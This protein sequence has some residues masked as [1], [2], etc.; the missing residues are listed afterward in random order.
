MVLQQRMRDRDE[1]K[2]RRIFALPRAK[3]RIYIELE[4]RGQTPI[5]KLCEGILEGVEPQK[6]DHADYARMIELAQ[7]SP[8]L[9]RPAIAKGDWVRVR[10]GMYKGDVA[11]V[12]AADA[13]S[14][15]TKIALVPRLDLS[16]T[17]QKKKRK[18]GERPERALFDA[19]VVARSSGVVVHGNAKEGFVYEKKSFCSGLLYLS[20]SGAHMLEKVKPSRDDIKDFLVSGVVGPEAIKPRPHLHAGD[21]VRI[22]AGPLSGS[23]LRVLDVASDDARLADIDGALAPIG[24][25]DI[26]APIES[27]R[28][29][30]SPGDSI[31]VM[32][33]QEEGR[34]GMVLTV[35]DDNVTAY[36]ATRHE[37]VR[38][39]VQL[40]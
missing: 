14:D 39:C 32:S 37:E 36:D 18:H 20:V 19:E 28:L 5:F 30:L 13:E 29:V 3:R 1:K 8:E 2:I 12:L 35:D 10:R 21:V 15:A 31:R 9:Q 7:D 40:T 27:L 17:K 11:L 25:Q 34:D 24:V 23:T 26:L 22:V 6:V 16:L 33:G 4:S 38:Q